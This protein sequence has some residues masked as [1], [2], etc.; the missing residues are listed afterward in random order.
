MKIDFEYGRVLRF[1]D[2]PPG[3]IALDGAVQGPQVDAVLR[4]FSFDHHAGCLRLVTL[5]TCEQVLLALKLGLVVDEETTVFINDIDAD[6]AMAVWLLKHGEEAAMGELGRM[7]ELVRRIGVTDSHG[8]IFPPHPIHSKIGYSPWDKTP[9]SLEGLGRFLAVIDEY[10]ADPSAFKGPPPRDE[11]SE[12]FGWTPQKGWE[13]VK[14]S[15]GF[16]GVYAEGFLAGVLASGPNV[17]QRGTTT[18]T[19]AKRSDLVPLAVGP[20]HRDR[21][22]P[23]S[24]RTDTILGRLGLRERAKNPDQP[25]STS[26]GGASSIG[27]SPRNSDGSSSCLTLEEVL[28]ECRLI[29]G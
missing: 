16:A 28:E 29:S 13:R 22:S 27:G 8:P 12:G 20:S 6:T 25:A 10:H 18:Y 1:E 9:Q 26:W 19:V 17:N 21:S 14:T 11:V 5:S 15:S 23:S 7:E 3:G 2:L 24:F 4:R